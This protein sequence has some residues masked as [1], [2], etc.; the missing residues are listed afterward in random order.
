MSARKP[1]TQPPD[2]PS[3]SDDAPTTIYDSGE[4]PARRRP[5]QTAK[6]S[7]PSEQATIVDKPRPAV[8][9]MS[10]KQQSAPI[11]AISMK[12]PGNAPAPEGNPPTPMLPRPKLRAVS[13][14]MPAQ[15]AQNFGTIAQPY[16]PKEAR[17]RAVREYVIWG[18]VAVI[19]ASV[20]A[21]AV[22]FLAR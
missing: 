22:W 17:A 3:G 10:M 9:A 14:V 2:R 1:P 18:C 20:I 7:A 21:L 16:D 13:E 19:L 8:Q 5:K 4:L 6:G 12:T 15:Q 11:Q